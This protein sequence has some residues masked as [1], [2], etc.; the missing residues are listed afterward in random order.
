MDLCLSV[1]IVRV[2]LVRVVLAMVVCLS[3][4]ALASGSASAASPWWH[5]TS[6]AE[7][8]DLPRGG[9]GAL[10][11]V[12]TNLGDAPADGATSPIRIMDALPSGL[13]PNAISANIIK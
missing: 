4:C 3:V 5:V 2:A 13:T 6:G 9:E 10:V 11:I 12:L 7:P 1:R 8:T